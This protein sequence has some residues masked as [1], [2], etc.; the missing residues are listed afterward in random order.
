M[1]RPWLRSG[2][3]SLPTPCN[4]TSLPL[5]TFPLALATWL[6]YVGDR[7]LDGL[8]PGQGNQL[9]ERHYFHARHRTAFLAAGSRCHSHS[10]P[11]PFSRACGPRRSATIFSSGWERCSIGLLCIAA[12]HP[13]CRKSSPWPSSLPLPPLYRH[14]RALPAGSGKEQLAPAVLFFAGLCWVNCVGIQK[15]ETGKWEAGEA[16]VTTRWAGLH[17]RA[18]VTMMAF[19]ALAGSAVRPVARA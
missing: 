6:L 17:L 18:I 2:P 3:G 19:F 12:T 7:I 5:Q 11:G 15:W 1:L 13:A 14:G 8:H 10:W 4:C 9:R 16:H